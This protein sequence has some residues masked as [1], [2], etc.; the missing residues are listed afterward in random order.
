MFGFTDHTGKRWDVEITV[1]RVR[2][3]ALATRNDEG[4]G[5]V[6]N[7]AEPSASQFVADVLSDR[8]VMAV[9]LWHLCWK[10]CEDAKIDEDEFYRRVGLSLND[11]REALIGAASVFMKSP[12]EQRTFRETIN[13]ALNV[14]AALNAKDAAELSALQTIANEQASTMHADALRRLR[15]IEQ[16]QSEIFQRLTSGKSSESATGSPLSP[17]STLTATTPT[18]NS[19]DSRSLVNEPS[20]SV[21]A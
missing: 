14:S 21:A 17:E 18:E 12:E 3:V 2:R 13:A 6:I 4:I 16:T 11:A 10:Q 5:K 9:V 15:A 7:I 1:S 19:S 8:I 20:G